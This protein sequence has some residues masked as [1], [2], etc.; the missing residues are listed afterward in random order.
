MD[1]WVRARFQQAEHGGAAGLKAK[2]CTGDV[3]LLPK[4]FRFKSASA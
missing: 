4:C 1:S 2:V 3:D